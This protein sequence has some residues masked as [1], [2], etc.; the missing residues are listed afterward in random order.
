MAE[1][2]E[3]K[4]NIELLRIISIIGVIILHYCNPSIGGGVAF[5]KNDINIYSLYVLC[6]NFI[7]SVDLFM[8]ISGYF[9]CTN[10]KRNLWKII[11]L[12]IQVVVFREAFYIGGVVLGTRVFSVRSLA[13]NAL[14]SNYFVILYCCVYLLSPYVNLLLDRLDIR[15]MKTFLQIAILIFSIYPT[16][17]DVLSELC[18][19]ELI[20]LSSVG[21]YGSQ[22]GYTFVN[23][24][25]M[26]MIGA[27]LRK[28]DSSII[29]IKSSHLI[30]ILIACI[31]IMTVWSRV[32]D[33][34]GHFTEKSA[35]EYCNP[36]VI[37]EAAVVFI[38]FRKM[39]LGSNRIINNLA[40]GSFTVFLIHSSFLSK[41][42]I[43]EFVQ[44][45]VLIMLIHIFVSCICIYLICWCVYWIYERITAPI[46]VFLEKRIKLPILH[47][48]E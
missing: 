43:E 36:L 6:S 1:K 39:D 8:L 12:V 19:Q 14:P 42:R 16:M 38:L 44:K 41:I 40:K 3:R 9:M 45:N 32:N 7:C 28:V 20:G 47:V 17:V 37:L 18:G 34:I 33:F 46:Y 30:A 11:R 29:K 48:K 21:M 26:Y 5:V 15:A 4:S 10:Y 31:M 22:W 35:W 23:F 25:L 13:G 2:V 27:Y 24:M